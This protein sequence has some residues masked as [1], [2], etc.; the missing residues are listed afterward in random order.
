MTRV[1]S[2]DDHALVRSGI[3]QLLADEQDIVLVAEAANGAEMTRQLEQTEGDVLLLDITMPGKVGIA[4]LKEVHER[5]P[6]IA[7]LMLTMH[8]KYQYAALALRAGAAGYV[9]KDTAPVEL[10]RAIRRVASGGRYISPAFAETWPRG[11]AQA[12]RGRCTRR[13]PIASSRCC[14][15]SVPA[16]RSPR[17]PRSGSSASTPSAPTEPACWRS[18]GWARPRS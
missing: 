8:P 15:G 6:R 12:H 7:V 18:C 11:S 9:C 17:S 4:L 13:C 3:R 14:A 1:L 10:L 5:W 16:D 2:V